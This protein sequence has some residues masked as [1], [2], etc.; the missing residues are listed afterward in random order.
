MERSFTFLLF[1]ITK[2]FSEN[3]KKLSF[4]TSRS[5]LTSIVDVYKTTG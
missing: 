3:Y 2:T 1:T 4:L 5:S